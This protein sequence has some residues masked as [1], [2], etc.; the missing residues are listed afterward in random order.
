MRARDV[1]FTSIGY[2]HGSWN[3]PVLSLN[4][5]PSEHNFSSGTPSVHSTYLS[6]WSATAYR[7]LASRH[8]PGNCCGCTV[9]RL[10][11]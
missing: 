9:L 2:W 3:T 5:S 7:A 1:Q 4:K 10:W 11:F 8:C 6:H